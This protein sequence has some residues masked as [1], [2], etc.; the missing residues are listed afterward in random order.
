[1][2]ENKRKR[3]KSGEKSEKSSENLVVKFLVFKAFSS[4]E[5]FSDSASFQRRKYEHGFG[6]KIKLEFFLLLGFGV[7]ALLVFCP[8]FCC[9]LDLFG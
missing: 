2:K 6:L 5:A 3:K 8:I 7:L 1:M 9:S 4:F